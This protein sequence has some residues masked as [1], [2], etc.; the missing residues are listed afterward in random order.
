MFFTAVVEDFYQLNSFLCFNRLINF[1]IG[2]S[3][4]G[5]SAQE[6]SLKGT[7][8]FK[9]KCNMTFKIVL[10]LFSLFNSSTINVDE[11]KFGSPF[12]LCLIWRVKFYP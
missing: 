10:Q 5:I 7:E 11:S 2:G 4:V 12:S 1:S 9:L 8:V 3:K 6:P